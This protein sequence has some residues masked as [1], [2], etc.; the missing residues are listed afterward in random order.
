MSQTREK[1]KKNRRKKKHRPPLFYIFILL[2]AVVI[3]VVVIINTV[4]KINTV[5][6]K[7][8]TIYDSTQIEATS[9]IV[10]GDNYFF[11][12]KAQAI[13]QIESTY[14]YLEGT[15][16]EYQ[17]F[18]TVVIRVEDA[19]PY[20]AIETETGTALLSQNFKVLEYPAQVVPD[21]IPLVSGL[22]VQSMAQGKTLEFADLAAEQKKEALETVIAAMTEQGLTAVNTVDISNLYDIR[23]LY[24]N[25]VIIL[26]GGKSKAEKKARAL[27]RAIN[28]DFPSPQIVRIDCSYEEDEINPRYYVLPLTSLEQWDKLEKEKEDLLQIDP[29]AVVSSQESSGSSETSGSSSKSSGN[30]S[31]SSTTSTTSTSS[32]EDSSVAS[33]ETESSAVSE[34]QVESKVEATP[35]KAE[36]STG[37]LGGNVGTTSNG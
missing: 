18:S 11:I 22:D 19:K 34:A 28:T 2:L 21:G 16:I 13:E 29:N 24:D 30:S 5:V 14:S 33:R 37:Y 20:F 4:F 17:M 1:K 15:K 35:S 6:V 7:G 12:N 23:M 26:F 32:K 36:E 25:R 27:D 8:N 3:T 31:K 9:Q 10:E